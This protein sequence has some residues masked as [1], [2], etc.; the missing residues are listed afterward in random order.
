MK[1]LSLLGILAV[2]ITVAMFTTSCQ[3]Q[4]DAAV[5]SEANSDGAIIK[6]V[7]GNGDWNGKISKEEALEM[8][9]TFKKTSLPGQSESVEFSI[10]D[11]ITYLNYLQTKYK[12][13][14]VYVN[15][16]VYDEKTAPK[17]NYVGRETIFFS[18]NNNKSKASGDVEGFDL[19]VND[20]ADYMNH[21]NIYP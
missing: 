19:M 10:K 18:G 12:S 8:F 3:K 14:K 1:K 11:V 7:A 4:Q 17:P 20:G 16:A 9:N 13:D 15:F 5:T 21:G 6:T 2:S